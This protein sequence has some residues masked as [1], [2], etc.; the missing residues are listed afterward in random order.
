MAYIK[1]YIFHRQS[2]SN[3]FMP[4]AY[5]RTFDYDVNAAYSGSYAGSGLTGSVPR[6][7]VTDSA[8]SAYSQCALATVYPPT[9][10]MNGIDLPAAGKSKRKFSVVDETTVTSQNR[11]FMT[12]TL[13]ERGYTK[14]PAEHNFVVANVGKRRYTAID[15]LTYDTMAAYHNVNNVMLHQT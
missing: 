6:N 4:Y 15:Y 8:A 7:H 5:G 11:N 12:P 14:T 2:P 13:Q 1:N 3:P 10:T 9:T